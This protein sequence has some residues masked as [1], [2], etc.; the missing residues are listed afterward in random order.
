MGLVEIAE[1]M[2]YIY[3]VTGV[4]VTISDGDAQDAGLAHAIEIAIKTYLA[5]KKGR[6]DV[7]AKIELDIT[8]T[9]VT[10]MTNIR[11]GGSVAIV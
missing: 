6:G 7:Y 5:R 2:C 8:P 9:K 1:R 4:M 10:F 3:G 11:D